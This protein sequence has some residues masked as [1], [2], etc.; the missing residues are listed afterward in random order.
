MPQ[1]VAEVGHS[2]Q[3]REDLVRVTTSGPVVLELVDRHH[4]GRAP[5]AQL[6]DASRCQCDDGVGRVVVLLES[7]RLPA[8]CAVDVG[9]LSRELL[10]L[11]VVLL[12]FGPVGARQFVAQQVDG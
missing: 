11:G 2:V 9:Q 7:Q 1:R 6:L 3:H 10:G 12:P 5:G 4:D 8:Q